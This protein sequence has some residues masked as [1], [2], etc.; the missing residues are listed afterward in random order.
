MFTTRTRCCSASART[1]IPGAT[2]FS[3]KGPADVLDHATPVMGFGSKIGIDA[4]HKLKG[5]ADTR[6]WPTVIQMDAAVKQ[7]M[8]ELLRHV[9]R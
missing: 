1:S 5:E 2:R 9:T 6:T 3:R 8:T 7:R 4:T